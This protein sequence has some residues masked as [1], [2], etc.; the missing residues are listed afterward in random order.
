MDLSILRPKRLQL[1]SAELDAAYAAS[2]RLNAH[3]GKTYYFST[4]FFPPEVRRS[5]HALYG[6]VRYPDEIVDNPPPSSNP[7]AMLDNYREATRDALKTGSSDLPVL[8]AF[9][10]MAHRHSLPPE[11]PMAFLDAMAMDLTRTRYE[12]FEDL[13]T[14]TYGSASVVGLMMCHVVGISD[15]CALAPAHD[16]G[17]AMQLTNFWR[18]IGEDWATRGRIY[19]PLEDME[20]FGYTES[21]LA[22]SIVNDQFIALMRFE[23][24]RA[25]EFY[26]ASDLGISYITPSCQMPVKL[27][28]ILYSRIL[29]KIEANCYDVFTRR[30]R[31][32][33]LEKTT[34]FVRLSLGR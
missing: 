19:L 34:E 31:T 33:H 1:P 13:K 7:A 12:T 11:Y 21:M 9:A 16:L 26:A 2:K 3:H 15:P 24:A 20:R 18:D 30:A 10:D 14:Y 29:D 27:A 5:V 28:R 4:L 17:L 25:R 6:F 8:H 22:E 32:T 23:I